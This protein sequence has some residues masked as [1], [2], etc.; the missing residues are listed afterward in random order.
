MLHSLSV[1]NERFQLPEGTSNKLKSDCND[2]KIGQALALIWHPELSI[3]YT[4]A[5]VQTNLWS[6]SLKTRGEEIWYGTL[7]TQTSKNGKSVLITSPTT[8]CSL[9]W[10]WVPWKRQKLKIWV[11]I[12]LP[13]FLQIKILDFKTTGKRHKKDKKKQARWEGTDRKK[14]HLLVREKR[15][16]GR[17]KVFAFFV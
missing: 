13:I 15:V 14:T 5:A 9:L 6:R 12:E 8:S 2:K 1:Q 16:V 10:K 3:L 7:A 11:K 4:L 17:V